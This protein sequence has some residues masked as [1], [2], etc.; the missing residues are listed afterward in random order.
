MKDNGTFIYVGIKAN[1]NYLLQT[2]SRLQAGTTF[3][4][5]FNINGL[6]ISDSSSLQLWATLC[7]IRNYTSSFIV[8]IFC[9]TKKPE[10]QPYLTDF[11]EELRELTTDGFSYNNI[12]HNVHI[13]CF[14]CDAPAKCF[15]KNTKLYSGYEGK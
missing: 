6:P 2:N 13:E 15:V 14:I 7:K 5:Q 11:V 3:H 8:A 4:L 12:T 9:G 10:L 1:L